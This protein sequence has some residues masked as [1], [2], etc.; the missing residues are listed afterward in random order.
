M[1]DQIG[2]GSN[3]GGI[4]V[5]SYANETAR[6]GLDFGNPLITGATTDVRALMEDA[7]LNGFN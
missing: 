5:V 7:S 3:G 4:P 1:V 2:F 6:S